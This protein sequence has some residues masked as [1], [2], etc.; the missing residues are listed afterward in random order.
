M[1]A[2]V[3]QGPLWVERLFDLAARLQTHPRDKW[4]C[5]SMASKTNFLKIGVGLGLAWP[6]L[7]K[8]PQKKHANNMAHASCKDLVAQCTPALN[9]P[10][11]EVPAF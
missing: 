6:G 7:P 9:T 10:K 11:P 8:H 2:S 1:V 5:S 4:N 3:S